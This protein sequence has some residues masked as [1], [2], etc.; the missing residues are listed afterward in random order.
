MASNLNSMNDQSRI[1]ATSTT[2]DTS[3]NAPAELSAVVDE[4]LNSL[5]NKFAG[6]S[7]EI[8]AKSIVP[9]L[10]HPNKIY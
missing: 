4:L 1:S 7:S 2:P 6:V 5:S 10:V 3:V 9:F 8:F